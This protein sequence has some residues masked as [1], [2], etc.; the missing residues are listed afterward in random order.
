MR[1]LFIIPFLALAGCVVGPNYNRP[2]VAIPEQFRGSPPSNPSIA[3]SKW[4]D[5]FQDDALK[6]LVPTA[7][8][9]NF[10]VRIAAERVLEARAQYGIVHSELYPTV[11]LPASF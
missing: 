1:A 3:D 10:D 9:Q 4:F 8:E 2:Q 7:L 11:S 6:Q 5:L